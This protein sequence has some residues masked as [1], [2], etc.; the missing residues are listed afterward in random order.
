MD[1]KLCLTLA[2]GALVLHGAAVAKPHHRHH[3]PTR[4]HRAHGKRDTPPRWDHVAG[5]GQPR[6]KQQAL[7]CR[8][9]RRLG[10]TPRLRAKARPPLWPDG[11]RPPF[12]PSSG[13]E[14]LAKGVP[15]ADAAHSPNT[16]GNDVRAK[17]DLVDTPSARPATATVAMET[18]PPLRRTVSRRTATRRRARRPNDSAHGADADGH[19][20]FLRRGQPDAG[21]RPTT[22][23]SRPWAC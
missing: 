6:L 11:R 21:G 18:A 22:A 2:C 17:V 8:P 23:P 3:E 5:Y 19:R 10:W 15:V 16:Y 9:Q 7:H 20:A 1:V 4:T 14:N 13:K 12:A